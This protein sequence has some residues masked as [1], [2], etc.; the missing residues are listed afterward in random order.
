[1]NLFS[2]TPKDKF[3][4]VFLNI[5]YSIYKSRLVICFERDRFFFAYTD[6]SQSKIVDF[7]KKIP[8]VIPIFF[9]TLLIFFVILQHDILFQFI[10]SFFS[11]VLFI[12]FYSLRNSIYTVII[13]N[14]KIDYKRFDLD[15]KYRNFDGI[16]FYKRI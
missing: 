3:E 16:T 8:V 5:Y 1:M 10:I 4:K 9:A 13:N 14:N 12:L 15:I 6:L 11:L 7:K 2:K